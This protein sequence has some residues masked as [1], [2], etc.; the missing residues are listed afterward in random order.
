MTSTSARTTI[1]LLAIAAMLVAAGP[2]VAYRGPELR[3]LGPSP[4]P[5]P[6]PIL[7][8]DAPPKSVAAPDAASTC[9]NDEFLAYRAI[10]SP[11]ERE[12]TVCGTVVT[13]PPDAMRGA[14]GASFALD[15]DGTPAIPVVGTVATQP[16]DTAI[17]HGRYHRDKSGADWI[18]RITQAV[19]RDWTQPGYAIINGTQTH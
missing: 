3:Q 7:N 10:P 9:A 19:A 2:A 16:G 4:I 11:W 14:S 15:V 12:V 1:G 5:T 17:V 6:T 8:V 18:D 13:V